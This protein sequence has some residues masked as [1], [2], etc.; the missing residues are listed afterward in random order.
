MEAFYHVPLSLWSL[1]ALLRGELGRYS[2]LRVRVLLYLI[3]KN[4]VV[5]YSNSEIA[6][7]PASPHKEHASYK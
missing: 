5:V 2:F 6:F 1:G 4:I 3:E 7:I